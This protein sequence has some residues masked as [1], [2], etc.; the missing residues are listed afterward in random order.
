MKLYNSGPYDPSIC[1]SACQA[2]TAY[3]HATAASDGTYKPCNFF[4][5]YIL[6]KNN[7]PQGTYCSFYTRT[8]DSSYAVNTGYWYGSDTYAVLASFTYALTNLDSGKVDN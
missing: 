3:D 1:A 6:T 5:S 7:V 8:W 4:N 2:Q